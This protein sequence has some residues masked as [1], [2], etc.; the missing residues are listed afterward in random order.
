MSTQTSEQF[1]THFPMLDNIVHLA[2]CS[3]GALSNEVD[4]SMQEMLESIRRH[5]A[6]WGRWAEVW[7]EA[8]TLFAAMIHASRDEIAIM[9]S[10]TIG[11]YQ[12]ASTL[13]FRKRTGIV[14]T[15]MEFP[16]VGQ[17][18]RG[19][20]KNGAVVTYAPEDDGFVSADEYERLITPETALVSVPSVSYKNG[21][22]LPVAEV[23]KIARSNGARV[24]IDA[25]QGAGVLPI[26][27]RTLDCDY[28][29]AGSLKYMLGL[30]GMAFLYIRGGVTDEINPSLTGWFGRTNPFDFDPTL[31]DFPPEAR[32]ME[33]GTASVPSAYAT[34]AGLQ[35]LATL[36][37]AEVWDHAAGLT[38]YLTDRL[39][40]MGVSLYSPIDPQLRGPQVAVRADDAEALG[41]F[42]ASRNISASPRGDV[43]RL[44]VHY[45]NNMTD[46]DA[47]IAALGEY[48]SA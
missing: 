12:V 3:Q 23:A 39:Q 13:S 6:P 35:L 27:V 20:E 22:R 19:Q 41:E 42:L 48:F 24:F 5:G 11:A 1:R 7:E 14:S 25:Y 15:E 31:T 29:V 36:D 43:V 40:E 9:P 18:W 46:M 28:L 33:S 37:P 4:A 10:A 8:R 45:Y 2:N 34:K 26:D 47:C 32:R 44:A 17:V 30:A 21:A 16:S 38:Q